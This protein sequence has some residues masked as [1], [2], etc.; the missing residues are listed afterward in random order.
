MQNPNDCKLFLGIL[1]ET[2]QTTLLY[3]T[4]FA[5]IHIS[6]LENFGIHSSRTYY[7]PSHSSH[8]TCKK[9]Q[10]NA[11]CTKLALVLGFKFLDALLSGSVVACIGW[12][13]RVDR[14]PQ[15]LAKS[16]AYG[17]IKSCEV[18]VS[19]ELRGQDISSSSWRLTQGKK[20]KPYPALHHWNACVAQIWRWNLISNSFNKWMKF[21]SVE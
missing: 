4:N 5:Y 11:I 1:Q 15:R 18:L 10:C 8:C 6:R 21:S 3:M 9:S 2:T 20:M 16:I 7:L 13:D 14:P 17:N 12:A 19:K